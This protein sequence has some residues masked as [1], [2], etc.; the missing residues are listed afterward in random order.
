MPFFTKLRDTP[1]SILPGQY[2]RGNAAGGALVS[3]TKE[4]V[5][6]DLLGTVPVGNYLRVRDIGSGVHGL[7]GRTLAQIAA[8]ITARWRL[9]AAVAA[10]GAR[11][12]I[13]TVRVPANA[14]C[15]GIVQINRSGGGNPWKVWWSTSQTAGRYDSATLAA[16]DQAGEPTPGGNPATFRY[17]VQFTVPSSSTT[18]YLRSGPHP[19]GNTYIAGHASEALTFLIATL[20]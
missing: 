16:I 12:P 5:L 8:E 3:A 4:A 14:I 19:P 7:E 10:V 1:E 17:P 6:A 18:I 11:Q 13:A 9:P 2:L 20:I 15:T